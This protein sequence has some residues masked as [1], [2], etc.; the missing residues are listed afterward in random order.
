MTRD[1]QLIYEGYKDILK[2]AIPYGVSA[3]IG[4]GI[5]GLDTRVKNQSIEDKIANA[6]SI[7]QDTIIVGKQ[8]TSIAAKAFVDLTHNLPLDDYK[9]LKDELVQFT[10]T[11]PEDR[12]R[13]R[14]EKLQDDIDFELRQIQL[15]QWSEK[16]EDAEKVMTQ[17]YLNNANDEEVLTQYQQ[18]WQGA[19]GGY[20]KGYITKGGTN[21]PKALG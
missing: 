4:A 21:V 7:F 16:D 12:H 1:E 15:N 8:P 10:E 20:G 19:G 13:E 2:K 18:S 5:Y 11:L 3:A 9:E 6:S 17:P 14:A